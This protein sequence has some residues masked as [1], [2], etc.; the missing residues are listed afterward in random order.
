VGHRA[1]EVRIVT[2]RRKELRLLAPDE[3]LRL[4]PGAARVLLKILLKAQAGRDTQQQ[5]IDNRSDS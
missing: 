3:P 4:T 5:Q 1:A 2:E